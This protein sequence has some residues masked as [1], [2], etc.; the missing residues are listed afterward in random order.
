MLFLT[1][2]KQNQIKTK[3]NTANGD[4]NKKERKMKKSITQTEV[5]DQ[6]DRLIVTAVI[7]SY[8]TQNRWILT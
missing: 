4:K 2:A 5:D 6:V 8:A 1:H 3:Q 7:I